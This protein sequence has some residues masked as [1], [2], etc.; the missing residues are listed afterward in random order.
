M[1]SQVLNCEFRGFGVSGI[2]LSR[3]LVLPFFY[4]NL[5][6]L[7]EVF[8]FQVDQHSIGEFRLSCI[9]C[10][11]DLVF[12]IPSWC[13][14]F[15]YSRLPDPPQSLKHSDLFNFLPFPSS[16]L[17]LVSFQRGLDNSVSSETF[18]P[19][20]FVKSFIF[21]FWAFAF[22]SSQW[23]YWFSHQYQLCTKHGISL[24][25][26]SN[27]KYIEEIHESH[28]SHQWSEMRLNPSSLW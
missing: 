16:W 12:W 7:R 23:S 18:G 27:Y 28:N 8:F 22:P 20:F 25:L 24:L 11:W 17:Q 1:I 15:G 3:R 26:E 6:N 9:H 10:L 13:P 4:L 21:F 5:L 14:E 19:R 2:L